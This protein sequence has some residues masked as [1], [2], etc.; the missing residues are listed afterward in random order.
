REFMP[1]SL[2]G[3]R[4]RPAF[5]IPSKPEEKAAGYGLKPTAQAATG[6]KGLREVED[7]RVG[8]GAPAGA[9]PGQIQAQAEDP[10]Q[11]IA[12]A[13]AVGHRPPV[14]RVEERARER[15]VLRAAKVPHLAVVDE[16]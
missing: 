10:E 11:G 12:D 5:Q 1:S 6:S 4:K 2:M 16:R 8:P 3:G 13:A 9:A 15:E 7:P 14:A